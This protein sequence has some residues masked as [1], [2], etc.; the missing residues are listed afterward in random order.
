MATVPIAIKPVVESTDTATEL[1]WQD[2]LRHLDYTNNEV[3]LPTNVIDTIGQSNMDK[4]KSRLSGEADMYKSALIGGP[5]VAFVDE[6]INAL[7]IMRT[8]AFSGSVISVASHELAQKSVKERAVSPSKS[9]GKAVI[10]SKNAKIPRPPN[11][12][13]LYRQEHHPKIR[14]AHPEFHNNDISIAVMLGKQWKAEPEDVKAQYKA[15]AESA[16]RKHAEDYPDYQ[17]APRKPSEKKRR[18]SS[19]QYP[20]HQDLTPLFEPSSPASA[21]SSVQTPAVSP[22][23]SAEDIR[24]H[25]FGTQDLSPMNFTFNAPIPEGWVVD[26]NAF[27]GFNPIDPFDTLVHQVQNDNKN[28]L[29]QDYNFVD[30]D[31]IEGGD[32]SEFINWY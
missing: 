6:S 19:R 26:A 25:E 14:E 5:V 11:A 32:L 10:Q 29:F 2:A 3:L 18:G 1:L 30:S 21:P 24:V 28:V 9:H 31:V 15:L 27:S 4:I 23:M 7:R 17:Y 16:K 8:P 20:K 22:A 13:I 12:F